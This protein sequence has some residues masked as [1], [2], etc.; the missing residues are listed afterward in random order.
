[1][2]TK[3]LKFLLFGEDKGAGGLFSALGS[4]ATSTSGAIRDS[5]HKMGAAIGGELGEVISKAS[6]GLDILAEHG[7]KGQ[8]LLAGGAAVA[9]IGTALQ[10]LGS[11]EQQATAQLKAAV[12]ASGYSW[13]EYEAD[14]EKAVKVQENYGHS[15]E[16]TKGALQKLTQATGDPKRALEQMGVVAN[17]AAE[18]HTSLTDAASLMAKV[19]NGGGGKALKEYGVSVGALENPV[20]E[21]AKAQDHLTKTHEKL[22]EAQRKY[23]TVQ[24]DLAGKTKLTAAEQHRLIKAHEDVIKAQ[25]NVTDS[26]HALAHAHQAQARNASEVKQRVEDLAQVLNGQ[27]DAATDNFAAKVNIVKTKIGDFA[28]E[29]AGPLGS[30]LQFLGPALMVVGTVLEIVSARKAAAAAASAALTAAQEVE[31]VATEEAT[32]AQTGLNLAFLA[33]PITLIVLGIAALIAA[34]VLAYNKISWFHDGVDAAMNG[35]KIAFGWIVTKATEVFT[36]LKG[37][38]QLVLAIIVGPIGL[39]VLF[40]A[41]HFDTIKRGFSDVVS[42]AASVFGAVTNA[43]VAPFRSAFNAVSALWNATLG[44]FSFSIPSWVPVIGGSTWSLPRMPQL[45]RGGTLANSGS[46]LVGENGPE[47]LTL[48]GGSTVTPGNRLGGGQDMHIH[49]HTTAVVDHRGVA[50]MIDT[51]M[52][53]AKAQGWTPRN[54]KVA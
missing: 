30:A 3:A 24:H 38:W 35:I 20:K 7:S 6:E 19:L 50:A 53:V 48:P 33:N 44:K 29:M 45:A 42:K 21:I 23:A 18:K 27:A 22:A 54:V 5:F 52:G 17:L 36:W 12:D 13:E 25:K 15:A 31:T 14:I 49:I 43:I 47:I 9:G 37:H 40:I 51:A 1:M 16:D 2:A 32:V 11:A 26:V 39:A 46:V 4:H 34:V 41:T 10:M 8:K 28:A